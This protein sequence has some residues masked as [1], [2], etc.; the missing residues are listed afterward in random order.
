[1]S[2]TGRTP[3]VREPN[4]AYPTERY[5]VERL[6]EAVRFPGGLWVEPAAG[7]GDVV[8][9]VR[10]MRSDVAFEAV[11]LRPECERL[12]RPECERVTI[13][14]WLRMPHD[15]ERYQVAITNPPYGHNLPEH[16]LVSLLAR[17]ELW[18]ALL[19]PL[20]WLSSS[21]RHSLVSAVPP[22]VYPLPNRPVFR[23][24]HGDQV[25]YA[26]MVYP[27]RTRRRAAGSMQV[28]GVTSREVRVLQRSERRAWAAAVG[29]PSDPAKKVLPKLRAAASLHQASTLIR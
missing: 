26:W 8:R 27:P 19:L 24:T 15:L 4:D 28:L 25:D 2:A 12:L 18:I 7:E 16:F 29:A 3:G 21:R 20:G 1:M 14:D 11:E 5:C 23:G 6:L 17:P 9:V 13:G 10:G 22:D